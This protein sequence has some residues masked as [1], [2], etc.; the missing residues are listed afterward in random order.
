MGFSQNIQA[1]AHYIREI[2]TLTFSFGNSPVLP[3]GASGT[4][5]PETEVGHSPEP[6]LGHFPSLLPPSHRVWW[7]L[8]CV[9]PAGTEDTIATNYPGTEH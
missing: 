9:G 7:S 1:A 4:P 2:S 5:I 3:A 6:S 8:D